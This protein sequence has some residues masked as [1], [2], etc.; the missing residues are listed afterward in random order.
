MEEM[1]RGGR[2][3]AWGILESRNCYR[4]VKHRRKKR[5][6][7][8]SSQ[9]AKGKGE[10]VLSDITHKRGAKSHPRAKKGI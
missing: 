6:L 3:L 1:K 9:G 8:G 10:G 5:A 2:R 4:S 7:G